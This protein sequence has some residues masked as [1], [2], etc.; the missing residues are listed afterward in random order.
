MNSYITNVSFTGMAM[1]LL[2]FALTIQHYFF[3]RA[4]WYKAGT[5]LQDSAKSWGDTDFN[6]ISF[7]NV[8]QDAYTSDL[9]FTAS[10]TDAIACSICMILAFSPV[11]GRIQFL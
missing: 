4:F 7:V 6:R 8:D 11:V 2:I 5:P 9:F 3:V 1:S 10:W